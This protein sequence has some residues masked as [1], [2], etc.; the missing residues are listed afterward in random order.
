MVEV[1]TCRVVIEICDLF[2]YRPT[3]GAIVAILNEI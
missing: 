2:M 3:G 1:V